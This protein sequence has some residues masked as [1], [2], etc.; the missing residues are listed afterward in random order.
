MATAPGNSRDDTFS[1]HSASGGRLAENIM[2]FARTLRAAG[3]PVGPGRVLDAIRATETVGIGSREDFYW[4]LHATLVNRREQQEI[5]DQAF[6]IFWRNP[7][8]LERAMAMLLPQMRGGA[9][10]AEDQ[11]AMSRR[12]AEALA[13][14]GDGEGRG[15]QEQEEKVEVDAVMTY[16]DRE[17]LRSILERLT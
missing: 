16:S 1:R 11:A 14:E 7:R 15:E 9:E 3:L 5:F 8:L 2:Y 12:L 10:S 13:R 6:H 4:A 17:L